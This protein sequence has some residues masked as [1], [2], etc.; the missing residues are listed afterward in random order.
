MKYE[1]KICPICGSKYCAPS[2]LSR[3]DNKTKICPACGTAEALENVP[4]KYMSI[5]DKAEIKVLATRNKWAIENFH[6]THN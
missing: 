5:R 3:K 6:D 1:E 2:A 4:E